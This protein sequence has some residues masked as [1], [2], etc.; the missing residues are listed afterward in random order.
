[1]PASALE[2]GTFDRGGALV[3]DRFQPAAA[4]AAA[5][6]RLPAILT[7]VIIGEWL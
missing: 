6:V 2:V 7:I 3:G 4:P 1:M 5:S